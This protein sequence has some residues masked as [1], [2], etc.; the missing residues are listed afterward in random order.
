MKITLHKNK[1]EELDNAL[2]LSKQVFKP[3]SEEIKKYHNRDDWLNKINNVGLL[4]TVWNNKK[5]VGFSICYPK[6]EN[7]HIW[8][9]GVLENYRGFGVWK[10]MYE[11][12]L[13]FAIDKKYNHLTLN[14]YKNKFAN[15]YSFC[16]KRGF[17]EYRVKEGK[18]YFIKDVA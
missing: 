11:A 12:I 16:L 7:F 15:M 2:Y 9:A 4:L 3:T 8:N 5:M 14:T 1:I 13:K 10:E 6:E 17:K 18:S